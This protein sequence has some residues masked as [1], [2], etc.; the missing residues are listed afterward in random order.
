MQNSPTLADPPLQPS[1]EYFLSRPPVYI[2]SKLKSSPKTRNKQ[3]GTSGQTS[4]DIV[5]TGDE[6]YCGLG[7]K[8]CFS[9]HG[10]R[11]GDLGLKSGKKD[12]EVKVSVEKGKF[13]GG[14]ETV[15]AEFDFNKLMRLGK[16]FPS[17]ASVNVSFESEAKR[18]AQQRSLEE[19]AFHI[20]RQNSEGPSLNII[21]S[22]FPNYDS[23]HMVKIRKYMRRCPTSYLTHLSKHSHSPIPPYT[24]SGSLGSSKAIHDQVFNVEQRKASQSKQNK[25]RK[26]FLAT[27]SQK[28]KRIDIRYH[29]PNNMG[30]LGLNP[31]VS[32]IVTDSRANVARGIDLP[33][34]EQ[35]KAHMPYYNN[36][37][38]RRNSQP[39][40]K[41]NLLDEADKKRTKRMKMR[42]L[43][44]GNYFKGLP[45]SINAKLSKEDVLP[46]YKKKPRD[47]QI[48]PQYVRESD[49]DIEEHV[50]YDEY[51]KAYYPTR[52][53][54]DQKSSSEGDSSL[55]KITSIERKVIYIENGNDVR[56]L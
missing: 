45:S 4:T 3:C 14:V 20:K 30:Y 39:E 54:I 11:R 31:D 23:K 18:I 33:T 37:L 47:L 19:S 7:G 9:G 52:N 56:L 28:L 44:L 22:G 29:P 1:R 25:E 10:G 41:D 46:E 26:Y 6:E 27:M 2:S 49:E 48:R 34:Q 35:L 15:K 55:A 36:N 40:E 51:G 16:R 42:L 13:E 53:K 21:D 38:L 32:K 8:R 12:K 24:E 43:D 50:R 17:R 5:N